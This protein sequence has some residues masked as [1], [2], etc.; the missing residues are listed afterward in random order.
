MRICK[1]QYAHNK[2][3]EIQSKKKNK[4]MKK[5]KKTIDIY[6]KIFRY[7]YILNDEMCLTMW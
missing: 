6:S 4:T 2:K 1:K 5:R 3:Q 7:L